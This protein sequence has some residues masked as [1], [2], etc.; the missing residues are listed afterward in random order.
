MCETS[1]SNLECS[2]LVF[3]QFL[4]LGAM[5]P[6]NSHFNDVG[7]GNVGFINHLINLLLTASLS[8][9]ILKY[10]EVAQPVNCYDVF[11]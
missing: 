11:D 8:S 5:F 6:P 1:A 9:P 10:V 7:S 2:L 3:R 4:N